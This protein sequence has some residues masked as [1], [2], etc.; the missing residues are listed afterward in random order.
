MWQ[1]TVAATKTAKQESAKPAA[2]LEDWRI[3]IS[4]LKS[5][6]VFA[7]A[8]CWPQTLRNTCL[9][10]LFL[11]QLSRPEFQKL[12]TMLRPGYRPPSREEIADK[13]LP[14]MFQK[15]TNQC[16]EVL[17][18]EIVSIT[19]YEWQIKPVTKFHP[20][21]HQLRYKTRKRIHHPVVHRQNI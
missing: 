1:T 14:S 20:D 19:L 17:K 4:G 5:R 21:S 15:E 12:I 8:V 2:Y 13:F 3:G 7:M 9:N 10:Y 11:R 18:G 16:K 6:L